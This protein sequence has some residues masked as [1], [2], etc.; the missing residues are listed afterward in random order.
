[1]KSV[2]PWVPF[3]GRNH[4]SKTVITKHISITVQSSF[5]ISYSLTTPHPFASGSLWCLFPHLL[6][7]IA[8]LNHYDRS[9][10]K[11]R[12][13][14]GAPQMN[15]NNVGWDWRNRTHRKG[16]EAVIASVT[17]LIRCLVLLLTHN[18]SLIL[19]WLKSNPLYF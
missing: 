12:E 2:L 16:H 19:A 18:V 3:W 10:S 5:I 17:M 14:R 4:L 15:R 6:F 7:L 11:K 8:F 9:Q 13:A 1:M